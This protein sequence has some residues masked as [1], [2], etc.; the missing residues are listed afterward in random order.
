MSLIY[1]SVEPATLSFL[2]DTLD[3]LL[4][5]S[6]IA[7]SVVVIGT[8][9][10][11]TDIRRIVDQVDLRGTALEFAFSEAS[12]HL[13]LALKMASGSSPTGAL[14][15]KSGVTV[16][17]A[18]DAR[19]ERIAEHNPKIGTVSPLCDSFAMF[20]LL[21]EEGRAKVSSSDT[22]YVDSLTFSLSSRTYIEVPFFLEDCFYISDVALE[23]ATTIEGN[24]KQGDVDSYW[25][26]ARL[27][28]AH[29]YL[30]VLGDCLYVYSSREAEAGKAK[31]LLGQNS[32]KSIIRA[33]PFNQLGLKVLETF[34]GKIKFGNMPGLDSR[35]VQLHVQHSWGGGIERWVRDYCSADKTRVNL[36]LKSSGGPDAFGE[37]LMLFSSIDD[38]IP[39]QIWKFSLPIKS[40]V[41][42]HLDYANAIAEIISRYSVDSILI[43]SLIGHSLDILITSKPTLIICHDYYPYC[44]AINI[45]FDKTCTNCSS[46]RLKNCFKQNIHNRYFQ[47]EDASAWEILRE[48]YLSL[49]LNKH[50]KLVIP[51]QSIQ[52]NLIKLEPRY[53]NVEFN[54][55]PHATFAMP[56]LEP[57][58]TKNNSN[59]KLKVLVLGSLATHKGQNLLKEIVRELT[60]FTNLYLVGCGVEGAIFKKEDLGGLIYSYE[61]NELPHIINKINPDIALLLS[62][63][64]ETFSYTL[65]ELVELK[66]P[67]IAT[68]L[69]SFVERIDDEKTGF[70]VAP[71]AED[72][73]KKLR[74]LDAQ[75][76]Q[77]E[78]VKHNLMRI[79]SKSIFEMIADYHQ[80]LPFHNLQFARFPVNSPMS[81]NNESQHSL[82]LHNKNQNF[83]LRTWTMLQ[84]KRLKNLIKP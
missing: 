52:K 48:K 80:L 2:Q 26:L 8:L 75:R 53:S 83:D 44:S 30:N 55:I 1:L 16:P 58:S 77:I 72:V 42:S 57:T 18:W 68:K 74:G 19:L 32:V 37:R 21:G 46:T 49:I 29:G 66:V 34:S 3:S 20:S 33:R 45:T 78:L 6:A 43:S 41:I 9:A 36:I 63:V 54:W 82:K 38:A 24:N 27:L 64:P 31:H 70:L 69:G 5:H 28:S 15:V 39:L 22:Q 56:V 59:V 84:L 65:S 51:S 62:V 12:D 40:T 61:L 76:H 60:H 14:F 35:P 10:N 79:K 23:L 81:F 4:E 25:E 13:P 47:D 7:K 71:V 67:V 73:I 50:L 11:E 17:Y